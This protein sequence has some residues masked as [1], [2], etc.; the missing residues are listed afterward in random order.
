TEHLLNDVVE[1]RTILKMNGHGRLLF[2]APAT[3][4]HDDSMAIRQSAASA[5]TSVPNLTGGRCVSAM[6]N[7]FQPLI[8]MMAR[9]R[10]DSSFSV[11]CSRACSYT[12]SGTCWCS[13]VVTASA[14]ASAARSR[15]VNQSVS[16]HA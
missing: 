5:I 2:E 4:G 3:R 12:S 8:A 11:N 16:R 13:R 14:H 15:G 6:L 7:R 10:S 9:V 1:Y